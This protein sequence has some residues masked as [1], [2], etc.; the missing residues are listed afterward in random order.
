MQDDPAP[1]EPG[2][3]GTV[4][5]VYRHEGKS[6]WHQIDVAWDNGRTLMLVSPPDEFEIIQSSS[7][8]CTR[9]RPTAENGND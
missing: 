4:I 3:T 6:T 7:D 2:Q 9:C 8:E 1:I 5:G